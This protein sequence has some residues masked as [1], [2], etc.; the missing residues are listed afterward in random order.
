MINKIKTLGSNEFTAE[1]VLLG[2][3]IEK[4]KKK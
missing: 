4:L 1:I 3:L 2:A